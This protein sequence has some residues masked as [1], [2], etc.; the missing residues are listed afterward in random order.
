MAGQK[1]GARLPGRRPSPPRH[2]NEEQK[3]IWRRVV[4]AMRAD[5]FTPENEPLLIAYVSTIHHTE[6]CAEELNRAIEA[7]ISGDIELFN[8]LT[9]I[10][11]RLAT[12]MAALATKL[13]L[14]QQSKYDEKVKGGGQAV[15]PT[16]AK[17][18]WE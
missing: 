11:A 2:L 8:R 1:Q 5:W 18:P 14:T 7:G 10:H 17:K 3:D 13:R 4:N 9:T 15:D 16:A 6:K 12:Q